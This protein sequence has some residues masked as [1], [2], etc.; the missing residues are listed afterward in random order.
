MANIPNYLKDQDCELI[1]V[2]KEVAEK[3]EKEVNPDLK[4]QII[5]QESELIR[6]DID[7]TLENLEDDVLSFKHS[8]NK[9]KQEFKDV[10]TKCFDDI[11][12][13]YEKISNE[14]NEF[15][16]KTKKEYESLKKEM[17]EIS[18]FIKEF[19]TSLEFYK[20]QYGVDNLSKAIEKFKDM[21]GTEKDIFEFLLKN[22]N[23]KKD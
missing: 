12:S 2:S 22:F 17:K 1:W 15:L 7:Y 20:F 9:Y 14:H 8:C 19:D 4:E 23:V 5:K 13:F 11:N 16:T 6:R 18:E 3:Y 21:Y 10:S